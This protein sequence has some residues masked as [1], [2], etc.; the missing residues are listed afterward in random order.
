MTSTMAH[1]IRNNKILKLLVPLVFWL[2]VW[3]LAAIGVGSELLLPTPLSVCR[4]LF[5]LAQTG[6]FWLSAGTTLLRIFLGAMCGT[7]AGVILAV[8]TRFTLGDWVLTPV[9]KIVRATPVASFI[10]LVIL[11]VT[12]TQIPGFISA[13]MV[14]PVIWGNVV[15]G[16]NQT[17]KKLL[18][19]SD[20]YR[21]SFVKKVR[22]IY[23]P[24]VRPHFIA[25]LNTSLGLAWKAGVAAEVLCVP[26]NSVGTQ[27]YNSKLYLETPSLFAWTIVII[28]LSFVLEF[29]VKQLFKIGQRRHKNAA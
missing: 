22:L 26:K 13:L 15:T 5:S 19:L 27:L 7:F 17:D 28:V 16:I 29:A 3:Q 24:S 23:I 10:I 4:V 14:M 8:L 2:A 20:V 25:A 1:K 9:I 6:E 18:E 11:W 21:F 12:R